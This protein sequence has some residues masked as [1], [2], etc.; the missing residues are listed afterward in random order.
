MTTS[1][2]VSKL[3]RSVIDDVINNVREA[4]LDEQVDEQVLQELKQ[5][6][7][8]KLLQSKAVEGLNPDVHLVAGGFSHHAQAHTV[9][10][11]PQLAYAAQLGNGVDL[12]SAASSGS[13][14]V[15]LPQG[16]VVYQQGQ[17]M[18]TVAPGL[19]L[20]QGQTTM[21]FPGYQPGQVYIQQ[22][23]GQTI[24]IQQPQTIVQ[25]PSGSQTQPVQQQG[26]QA[27][28]QAGQMPSIVQVQS[29]A[30][31]TAHP[32]IQVDGA[33]DTSDEDDDD[34][35]DDKEDEEDKDDEN[36]DAEGE[37][38][39]PLNSEDDVSDDDPTDLFDID[40]VVVCQYERINRSKNKWKFHLKDGIMNL[41]GKDYVFQKATGD[42]E[43]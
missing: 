25:Q 8:T 37:E 16:Q 38:E 19:T 15:A 26:Q 11:Q 5:V 14:T 3:Y 24:Q 40:N 41:G 35:D 22:P 2:A 42:A 23:G 6:W 43:W 4:F 7:E 9:Q 21:S 33:N 20:P 39:E 17:V 28:G 27:Q 31:T 29:L 34:D 13:A 36:D 30:T 10:V 12:T 32:I 18:R 1:S